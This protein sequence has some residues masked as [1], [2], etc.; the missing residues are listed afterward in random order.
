M[1]VLSNGDH[2]IC[3][4]ERLNFIMLNTLYNKDY[5]NVDSP[6]YVGCYLLYKLSLM[7]T[8]FLYIKN[9]PPL[10]EDI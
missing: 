1:K 3:H 4:C 9:C 5:Y 6:Y 2:K 10:L 7:Q 8:P